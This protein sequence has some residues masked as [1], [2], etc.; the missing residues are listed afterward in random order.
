MFKFIKTSFRNFRRDKLFTSI[1]ILGLSL[2]T[3]C[4]LILFMIARHDLGFDSFHPNGNNIYRVNIETYQGDD[5]NYHSTCPG[6][7]GPMLMDELSEVEGYSRMSHRE[8]V[9]VE[10][11]DKKFVEE[12]GV[13][14]VESS[15]FS[16]F[17]FPLISGDVKLLDEPSQIFISETWAKKYFGRENYLSCVGQTLKINE[18]FTV[19]IAGIMKD[20]PSNTDLPFDMLL[21]ES[22]YAAADLGYNVWHSIDSSVSTFVMLKDGVEK[23]TIQNQLSELLKQHGGERM[24]S[25]LSLLLQPLNTIHFDERFGNYNNRTTPPRILWGLF[26]I[27]IVL[28]VTACINFI[29]LST[30][31][32]IKRSKEVGI[33]KVLGVSRTELISR[34]LGETSIITFI[35]V[36]LAIP[37]TIILK[38]SIEQMIGYPFE[39][40]IY[41]DSTI[42]LMII[43]IGLVVVLLSG[44]YPAF[45]TSKFSAASALKS[46]FHNVAGGATNFRRALVMAQFGISQVLLIG[47]FVIQ[48]QLSYFI[49][50]EMGFQKDGIITME[51]PQNKIERGQALKNEL[52][53]TSIVKRASLAASAASSESRR[54]N[55]FSFEGSAPDEHHFVDMK[56]ADNDY[57]A[58]YEFKILAGRN[59]HK[60]DSILEL[61][62]NRALIEEMGIS[63][64]EDAIGKEV[65]FGRGPRAQKKKITGVVENF[66]TASLYEEV[67][68]TVITPS[69]QAYSML[70]IKVNVTNITEAVST[71]EKVWNKVYPN[72]PFNYSF[73]DDQIKR[74]YEQEKQL[75]NI[76]MWF[77]VVALFIGAMGLYGLITFVVNQRMKELGVRKVLGASF[78]N[79]FGVISKEFVYLV[80]GSFLIAG[81]IAWYLGMA[82]LEGYDNRIEMGMS[83][84]ALALF[85]SVLVAIIAILYKA[86]TATRVNPIET[87]RNE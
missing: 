34:F 72:D 5:T 4:A 87:L 16:F 48:S 83:V 12:R 82:W 14:L 70:N 29:N 24:S 54:V 50:A 36:M 84:F 20:F 75:A 51:L 65:S 62:A 60:G 57:L 32:A 21:S 58:L 55:G 80:L 23:E 2:G 13:A 37:L 73:M 66:Y 68:P 22:T 78:V 53:T 38:P 8:Q 25:F 67:G 79:L 33:R 56:M 74:Y 85:A 18:E 63:D 47:L 15:F 71:L 52:L 81:P 35:S 46:G 76:I 9:I 30:A 28:L 6:P 3:S 45:F 10:I 64:P 19:Q 86:I 43:V 77:T 17:N 42:W 1:N 41:S 61:V 44:V 49:N 11:G 39:F 27:G 40:N 69:R 59:F 7:T 26:I 31:H